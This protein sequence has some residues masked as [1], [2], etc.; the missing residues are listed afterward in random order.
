MLGYLPPKT[1]AWNEVM[2]YKREAY[3]R[4]LR[5]HYETS[6]SR[7][8]EAE[9][10]TL[11]QIAIDAP[12][13]EP[14]VR[15]FSRSALQRSLIR[16]LYVR[17]ITHPSSGYVQGLNDVLTPFLE[18]FLSRVFH[19]STET[20]DVDSLAETKLQ[21]VEGDCYWCFC[22]L[23]DRVEHFY[24]RGQPGIRDCVAR[25]ERLVA[26]IDGD[27]SDAMAREGLEFMHF[28]IRWFNCLLLREVPFRLAGRLWD[29]YIAEVDRFEDFIVYVALALLLHHAERVRSMEFQDMILFLQK[30]PT[31]EWTEKE[32]EMTLA[33]AHLWMSIFGE[34]SAV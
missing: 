5:E 21:D 18:T 23:M 2:A 28:S 3:K 9:L 12:R 19:G 31:A 32:V 29:T 20:W 11:R 8:S 27:L 30:L 4:L 6:N 26:R 17:A 34:S 13:T 1:S 25:F 14:G 7:R 33:T 24:T 15:L 22:K 10:V 16:I